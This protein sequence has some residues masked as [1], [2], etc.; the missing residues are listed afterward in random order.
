MASK[1]VKAP[2]MVA[3]TRKYASKWVAL[4]QDYSRVIASA[5]TLEAV[6][7]KTAGEKKKAVFKVLPNVG[8]APHGIH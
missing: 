3:L 5:N 8:Y 2:K 1:I 7:K 4:S 6:L